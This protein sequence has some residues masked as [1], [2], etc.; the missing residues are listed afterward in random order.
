MAKV[1]IVGGGVIGMATAYYLKK[2]GHEIV[3]I[4]KGEPGVGCSSG[5]MGWVCP[6][7]SDPVPAPGLI[8]TSLK[9]MLKRDSPLYIKPSAIPALS[10]WLYLFWKSCNIASYKKGFNAGLELSRNT[11]NLF[12]ELSKDGSI[13][14]EQYRQG[15]LF[16]F[17]NEDYIEEKFEAYRIVE[18]FGLPSPIKKTKEQV[19]K[20]EPNLSHNVAGGLY[21]PSERH[22]RPESFTK[23]LAKWLIRNGV[24]IQSHNE[25][26]GFAVTGD[27]VTGIKSSRG[28]VEGDQ[29]LITTGA[30]AG[31]MLSKVGINVPLTAGKGYSLTVASPKN[32]FSQPLYLGDSR[33]TISPFKDAVRIGGTMEI[34]GIN[35]LL[36]QRRIEGLRRSANQY[37]KEPILGKEQAWTGM[38]PMTPDGLPILGKVP[39][40]NNM[41]I[42]T[43]HA[44][45]GIS[46]SLST[47]WAMADVIS[48]GKSEIDLAPFAA[49]RFMRQLKR[50]ALL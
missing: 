29:F 50:K 27:K 7:L 38:R 24:D 20:M 18:K 10:G 47:G 31:K 3:I 22:I 12:D 14:F 48:T 15:L 16:V 23:A 33:V 21:L 30:W 35:T 17:L 11:L 46:M 2:I 39:G 9:W 49:D 26:N 6:S 8:G 40:L 34:S 42:A 44:M 13:E 36:D 32:Q 45:S 28:T 1:V 41:Y 37:L 25:V 43:G 4:D 5:N 19:L